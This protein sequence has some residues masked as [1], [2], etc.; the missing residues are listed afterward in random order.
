M[1]GE[2]E[3]F[4]SVVIPAFDEETRI[5]TTLRTI[6]AYLEARPYASEVIVVG[7]GCGDRTCEVASACLR[8]R[9]GDRVLDRAENRGKGF[10]VAEGVAASRGGFVL[11][12]DADLSTPIEEL[13]K[14]WP[15]M[16]R[17]ADVV[18]GS[19]ALPGSDVQVRQN[20]LREGMGK[21]FNV[22]VRLF[23]LRG[24]KD[25]QCGF[26]L[27]RRRAALDIFPRLK[28]CGFSFD[29]EALYLARKRGFRI[30]QVPVIWRNCADEPGATGAL[31]GRDALGPSP[32]PLAPSAGR[33]H[34][35]RTDLKRPCP[36][37][38]I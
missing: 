33:R 4:L 21:V 26:K 25:T 6:R 27:F 28:L 31:L 9:E 34:G 13:E 23:V 30:A 8:G 20:R 15:E 19:R 2:G 11:F 32:D 3:V 29:V 37:S 10:S 38:G 17:G 5:V 24:I 14:L 7:D 12:S 1:T 22:F 36:I 16:E 35:Q 18:I